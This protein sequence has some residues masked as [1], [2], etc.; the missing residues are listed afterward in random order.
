MSANVEKQTPPTMPSKSKKSRKGI[1]TLLM[2]V[3]FFI[4]CVWFA[5]WY[6]VLRHH[7]ETDDAY[8]AGNQIQIMSQVN[9]SVARVNVD[10]TDFVKKGDVLVELDPTDA[11]QAFERSKTT[12]ANSVRQVHQQMINVR[13]Y[14]ANIDLQ[15][16][17]LDKAISDLNRREVLGRANAIGREDL[18][19]ARDQVASAR[20]SLEAA[21]QQY[22]ATQALVL[23]TSLEQQ[24]AIAQAAQTYP[25]RQP[26]GWLCLP[27]QRAVR[28]ARH[29]VVRPDG[30]GT[31]RSAVGRRQ[32]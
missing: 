12:L 2:I 11:E 1:L 26:G 23:N 19:H 8:V 6:L 17:A 10:N 30:G 15:Q 21:K 25:Y 28:R 16:I 7:Q 27:P 14:Q 4:G 24:P 3:F 32:L 5:Y 22:A 31:G 20:A 29:P 9:G 18:Q 13:Q